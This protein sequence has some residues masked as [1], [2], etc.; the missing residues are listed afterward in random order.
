M[1]I[2]WSCLRGKLFLLALLMTSWQWVIFQAYYWVYALLLFLFLSYRLYRLKNMYLLSIAV[3]LCVISTCLFYH[4]RQVLHQP[5]VEKEIQQTVIIEPDSVKKDGQFYRFIGR[6]NR[7]RYRY[8]IKTSEALPE[9]LKITGMFTS[10][11][12]TRQPFGFNEKLY[13]LN[14]HI[15]GNVRIYSCQPLILNRHPLW[16]QIRQWR[17]QLI[18]HHQHY[19]PPKIANYLNRLLLGYKMDRDEIQEETLQKLGIIHLFSLSGLHISLILGSLRYVLLRLRCYKEWLCYIDPLFLIGYYFLAGQPISIWRSGGMYV[20]GTSWHCPISRKDCWSIMLIGAL[21]FFP[22]VMMTIGGVLTFLMSFVLIEIAPLCQKYTPFWQTVLLSWS[23]LIVSVPVL[24]FYFGQ[25]SLCHFVYNLIFIPIFAQFILPLLLLLFVIQWL[26][27]LPP[28]FLNAIEHGFCALEGI[29]QW[30]AKG[31]AFTW[32][33]G[34]LYLFTFGIYVIVVIV[35]IRKKWSLFKKL[36]LYSAVTL[37]LMYQ[38]YLNPVGQVSYIDVGQGD[39]ILIQLPFHRGDYLIDTGGAMMTTQAKYTVIPYLKSQGVQHLDGVYLT[40]ADNDHI[41]DIES[42]AKE[43]S[44]QHLYYPAGCMQK[45]AFQKHVQRTY[46]IQPSIHWQE[47]IAPMSFRHQRLSLE[48]LW[49]NE[50]GEGDNAHSLVLK[51]EGLPDSFLFTGDLD[52]DGEQRLLQSYPT[53]TVDVLKIGHHGSKTSTSE[54]WMTQLKAKVGII[55]C[56][57]HNRYHHPNG[58][59][60]MRLQAHQVKIYR[61]DYQGLIRYRYIG[62]YSWWEPTHKEEVWDSQ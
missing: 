43:F 62:K 18:W 14:Q 35:C 16:W 36:S 40:H 21:C 1:N 42:I 57:R 48:L 24:V 47:V 12:S 59:V 23:L 9:A 20:L 31:D 51:A 15:H 49:P 34:P 39:S 56:G 17:Q 41:G 52:V 30:L 19:F 61:T 6:A 22:G 8:T 10:P 3:I 27:I 32:T 60:M 50:V 33:S 26:L 53:L 13:A 11:K 44:I 45:E 25:W 29:M 54:A 46:R 38:R 55:S 2:L 37:V 7:K 58:E 28:W 4:H 5:F